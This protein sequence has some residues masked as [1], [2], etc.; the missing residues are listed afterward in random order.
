MIPHFENVLR[1]QTT[2]LRL[3]DLV[4]VS[5]LA[6]GQFG[7]IYLVRDANRNIYTVKSL[8]KALLE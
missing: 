4:H 1:K 2:N 7:G 6:D 5:K 8:N 3:E